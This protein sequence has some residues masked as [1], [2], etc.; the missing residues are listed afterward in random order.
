MQIIFCGDFFQLPAVRNILYDDGSYCFESD[1]FDM[2]FVH[3]VFLKDVVRQ[4]QY[5]LINAIA[6]LSGAK[7]EIGEDT[8]S[9]M[10]Q[11]S[12]P[13]TDNGMSS[14]NL[15]AANQMANDYNINQILKMEGYL[16]EYVAQDSVV[17]CEEDGV[18][19][20]FKLTATIPK[21]SFTVP[22][23]VNLSEKIQFPLKLGFA[24]TIHKS[25]GMTLNSISLFRNNI[26]LFR[27]SISFKR[28]SIS[29]FRNSI[30]FKRNSFS[31]K[32]NSI[33]L[34]RNTISFK[35][36]SISL[37]RNSI[38]LFRNAVSFN[39]S[40]LGIVCNLDLKTNVRKD[41]RPLHF[42]LCPWR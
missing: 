17:N 34:F 26:S 29:L 36:N 31:F 21:M 10:D 18:P 42:V 22:K 20:F 7:K 24:L 13:L 5:E 8:I 32:Q 40:F 4:T 37:F 19:V 41:Y 12:R 11:L 33:S 2:V 30:S 23:K 16:F 38:S 39:I 35:R 3:R 1:V 9:L 27:N 28:N 15:F 25:Q 14:F 6:E